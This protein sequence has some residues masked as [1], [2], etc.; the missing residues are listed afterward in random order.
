MLPALIASS[1][2]PH[3]HERVGVL[4]VTCVQYYKC[5]HVNFLA[6]HSA[7]L[8]KGSKNPTFLIIIVLLCGLCAQHCAGA[9]SKVELYFSNKL[10]ETS[11]WTLEGLPQPPPPP[12]TAAESSSKVLVC[13]CCCCCCCCCSLNVSRLQTF[14]NTELSIAAAQT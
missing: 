1:H 4:C 9:E 8:L 13:C 6:A 7:L 14:V 5:T 2:H 11:P 12:P 3:H 10:L